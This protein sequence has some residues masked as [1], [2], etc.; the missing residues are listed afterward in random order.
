MHG[1]DTQPTALTKL[2]KNNRMQGIPSY[3]HQGDELELS[4]KIISN[5][6]FCLISSSKSP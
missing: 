3:Q 4:C 1:F 5:D 2:I 6:L